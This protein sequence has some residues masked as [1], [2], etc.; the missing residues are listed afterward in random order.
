MAIVISGVNNNDKI[1][2]S[3]G[4]IDLLSGVTYTSESTAPSFRIGSNI[5]L[6]NAGIITATSFSGNNVVAN[7]FINVGSNIQLGNAG[8]ATATTFVG[9]LT[10]NVNNTGN[11]LLQIGGSEKFRVGGSGQLGIGGANY[12]TSGQVLTSG[13]SGSAATWSTINGTTINNN[14]NNRLITGSGTANTLEAEANLIFDGTQLGINVSS[15]SYPLDVVGD[16]GGS[17][18]ASTNST[19]GVLSVV[20]KNSSGSVSA[21]SRIKSYPDGSSNQSHMAFETRNSSSQMVEHAR[22][23]SGGEFQIQHFSPPDG[24]SANRAARSALEIKRHYPQKTSGNYWIIDRNGTA[25]EIYCEMETDGGGWMLWHDHNAQGSKTSMNDALGGTDS[26]PSS[27]LGR[28]YYNNY[29]YYTVWIKA[30]Q[31]DATG[32]RLHSFVTLDANG[33]LKYVADYGADFLYENVG[34]QY[35][36]TK[37]YYF[38]S[39]STSEYVGNTMMYQPQCGASGWE[40]FSNGGW[41]E[42]YI[43][44]MDTRISPGT[45]RSLHLVER[46]YNFDSNGVPIWT[47]AESMHPT[48]HWSDFS[49]IQGETA[50]GQTSNLQTH[51]LEI[52]SMN[53]NNGPSIRARARGVLTGTFEYTFQ[54]GYNWGWSIGCLNATIGI[55]NA[56]KAEDTDPYSAYTYHYYHASLYNNSSNNYWYPTSRAPWQ[57][58]DTSASYSPGINYQNHVLWRETDGTIYARDKSGTHSNYTF[59]VKFAGPLIMCSGSQSPHYIKLQHIW[60]STNSDTQLNGRNR[61]YK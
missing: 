10:G 4:T 43:R 53:G 24:S 15:P 41:S 9:N 30:S 48:P 60:N 16:G 6:G 29:A 23:T 3:D 55:E 38:E 5:Q 51:N 2:A 42:V 20:G 18:S 25:R 49:L 56:L 39:A 12:G 11:L 47:I 22:I 26:S 34:D 28:G 61:W 58:S 44:E 54:L 27:N 19:N 37:N 7:H 50:D 21:I 45:H 31:I 35:D 8:V 40:S 1:T 46:I 59:P 33:A 36:P 52:N 32:E 13:G 57:S 14:A 17:F